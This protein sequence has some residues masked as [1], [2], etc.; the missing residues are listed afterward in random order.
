M[1]YA[2]NFEDMLKANIAAEKAG[3]A[4]YK[5]HATATKNPSVK[6]LLE[7]IIKDEQLHLQ[8]FEGLL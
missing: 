8:F 4:S 3:I 2:E 6:A 1:S 5:S 7:R